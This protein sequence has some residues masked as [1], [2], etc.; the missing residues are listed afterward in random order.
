VVNPHTGVPAWQQLAA[1]LRARIEAGE[2]PPG[3][4]LPPAPRLSHEHGL[5]KATV[6]RALDSLRTDGLVDLD[7]GI[8]L[9]VREPVDVEVVKVPRGARTRSR[10]PT[11]GERAQ[12]G[13]PE[14]V[15]LLL[16]TYGGKTVRYAA[17]RTELSHS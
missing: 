6:K 8:G 14:N 1:V 10:M 5:G 15:P 11:P 17:D 3:A 13:I 4:L 9:R 16:V 12:L 7:R 2:W